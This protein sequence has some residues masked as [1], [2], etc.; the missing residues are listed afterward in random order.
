M[1]SLFGSLLVIAVVGL[2]AFGCGGNRSG[3]TTYLY[4]PSGPPTGAEFTYKVAQA[5]SSPVRQVT[6]PGDLVTLHSFTL[7]GTVDFVTIEQINVEITGNTT[8]NG[9]PGIP[10]LSIL[11]DIY[12]VQDNNGNLRADLGGGGDLLVASGSLAL[13]GAPAVTYS[14]DFHTASYS[15]APGVATGFVLAVR[16]DP[17]QVDETVV[18]QQ[19]EGVIPTDLDIVAYD[20]RRNPVTPING[21]PGFGAS[22]SP[23][24]LGINDHLV[25]SEVLSNDGGV[26]DSFEFIEIFNPS[27]NDVQLDNYHLTDFTAAVNTSGYFWLP[28]NGTNF[29]PAGG[30]N[31][32]TEFSVRFPGNV[33]MTPGDFV[34]VAV[35]GD[36]YVAQFGTPT[37][38]GNLVGAFALVPGSTTL[39]PMMTWDGTSA[40]NTVPVFNTNAT[41]STATDLA[42]AGEGII[43]FRYNGGN[44][45]DLVVDIDMV[46]WGSGQTQ[47]KNGVAVDGGDTDVVASTY[48]ADTATGTQDGHRAVAANTPNSLQRSDYSESTEDHASSGNGAGGH[49]ETSEDWG[50]A[51]SAGTPTPGRLP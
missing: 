24:L 35:N 47:D 6:A 17:A 29:G 46:Y 42:D 26:T 45:D 39:A 44:P 28:A 3:T 18:G 37:L 34:I 36:G 30:N 23:V 21:S 38:G 8:F 32:S 20:A 41:A 14:L 16:L 19:I 10:D 51:F 1:R 4:G 9:A 49:D 33:T 12:L 50:S 27:P 40:A 13:T 25:I 5:P 15:L 7:T 2:L 11:T 43:L 31:T 22:S 48:N